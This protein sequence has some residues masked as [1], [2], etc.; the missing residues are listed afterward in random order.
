MNRIGGPKRK[1]RHKL[2]KR[3]REKG[4]ISVSR[5]MQTFKTG[6]KVHLI[7]EPAYPKGQYHLRF[8]GKTGIVKKS[9]GKC[10]EILINDKGKDK[11]LLIH[12]VHL[13]ASQNG[14]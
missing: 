10:Y 9:R 6:Q 7:F 14:I 2:K 4:K 12:P 5:F 11:T 8:K 3:R 13:K 1:S